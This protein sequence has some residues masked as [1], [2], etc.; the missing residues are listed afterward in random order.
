MA[1]CPAALSAT[2]GAGADEGMAV[3]LTQKL[4]ATDT[5]LGDLALSSNSS[6]NC[7]ASTHVQRLKW[8]A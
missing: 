1:H 8:A 5:K 7:L 3:D 4:G 2:P 6:A